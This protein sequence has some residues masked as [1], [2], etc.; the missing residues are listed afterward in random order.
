MDY[1][2]IPADPIY[3]QALGRAFYNFVYLEEIVFHMIGRLHRKGYDA[4]GDLDTAG[5]IAKTL[6]TSINRAELPIE[7]RDRLS[8]FQEQFRLAT[9]HERNDL[10]HSRPYS[11][12][13]GE[14]RLSRRNP[15]I[16]STNI[17]WPLERVHE[18][19]ELFARLAIEGSSIFH[20]EI[21]PL[22]P[23]PH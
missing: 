22:F 11:T 17:Y 16:P 3:L 19:A 18:A 5:Q 23:N 4:V 6:G 13:S 12:P 8:E 9:K 7:L 20:D 14:Q 15:A 1:E 2:R 21:V 10:L